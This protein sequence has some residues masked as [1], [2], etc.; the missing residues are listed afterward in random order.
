MI[1][2]RP[3][4]G[5]L[6]TVVGL[7]KSGGAATDWLLRIGCIVR[8]TEARQT[9]ELEAAA[10]PLRRAGAVVELGIHSPDFVRGSQLV[11]VSPGV[12]ASAPPIR[13]ARHEGI[14]VVGELE[15]GSWYC[16]G[17]IV[18]VTGS[19]GKSTVVTLV[20][21]ILKSAGK[22]VVVC[23][24]I[25]QPICGV[26]SRIRPTTTVVLEVSS[27]QLETSLAFHPRIGC[28]LNVTG[29]HLDRHGSFS[30]YRE[31]KARLFSFQPSSEWAVL[32]ADDSQSLRLRAHG[33]AQRAFFSRKGKVVGACLLKDRL[34]LNL[35]GMEE[36]VCGRQELYRR[37]IHHEE[38][39][40]AATCLTGLLGVSP[41][42]IG[43]VL[44]SFPGLPHR[45]EVVA[46]VGEVTF[47]NDSKATTVAAGTRAIE[48]MPGK[49][50]LIAGGRDKGSDFR[51]LR[52]FRK[53][54]RGAVLIGEDGPK[55]A[56]CLKGAVPLQEARDLRE[57]VHTAF[58]MARRGEWVLLSPMCA[59]FDMF[60][61]FEER[62]ER[63]E[64]AVR[65]LD[66]I[67]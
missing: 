62:G 45:Q 5:S 39:A 57:A 51:V 40:L 63:F 15:L 6:V 14:P 65:E 44:R 27:F 60:R 36:P 59:S 19:N 56:S 9:P 43:S 18:A 33:H 48:A 12:A 38:N 58:G 17:P 46:T 28:L 52:S 64:E 25:G 23:G 3:G 67:P 37:G 4:P 41:T 26:L 11:V 8:V 53:K 35:P 29:N 31:A 34:I 55:I 24:N 16:A 49:G 13:W 22:E 21:Q 47:V 2:R 54:L 50:I 1:V 20:G 7:A 61:D 30:E 66:A 32:N 42:V 10:E